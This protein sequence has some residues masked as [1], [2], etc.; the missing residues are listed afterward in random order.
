MIYTVLQTL[1][2]AILILKF[3]TSDE[4]KTNQEV[5]KRSKSVSG[6][7]TTGDFQVSRAFLLTDCILLNH[8][9]IAMI[10]G[11]GKH[12]FYLWLAALENSSINCIN[13]IMLTI[14][15]WFATPCRKPP[16]K[17]IFKS[18]RQVCE[19]LFAQYVTGMIKRTIDSNNSLYFGL[20][21]F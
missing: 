2:F 10:G 9:F 19:S 8:W 18:I 4:I 14:Y 21:S 6:L 16:D 17:N 1:M 13:Q 15:L 11:M 3:V 12:G 5:K 7:Y 20:P